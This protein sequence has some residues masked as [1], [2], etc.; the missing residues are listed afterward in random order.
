[1]N[2]KTKPRLFSEYAY[3]KLSIVIV[4]PYNR[5]NQGDLELSQYIFKD[6]VMTI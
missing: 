3:H 4:K 6:I 1:M 2:Y 5:L